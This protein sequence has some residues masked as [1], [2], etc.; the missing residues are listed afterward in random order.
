MNDYTNFKNELLSV[1]NDKL[2]HEFD[3]FYE[4]NVMLDLINNTNDNLTEDAITHMVYWLNTIKLF[5]IKNTDWLMLE[6]ANGTIIK[7]LKRR[8][9]D[10]EVLTTK[11]NGER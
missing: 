11:L 2:F 10:I 5:A 8:L 1:F 3:I 7:M 9:F 4:I 6:F